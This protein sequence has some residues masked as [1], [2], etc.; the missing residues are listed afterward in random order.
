MQR[1]LVNDWAGEKRI[2]IIFKCDRQTLE[3]VCPLTA[4]MAFEPDFIDHGLTGFRC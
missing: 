1:S 3:P 4:Q 2:A